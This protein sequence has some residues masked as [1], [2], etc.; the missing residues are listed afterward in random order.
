MFCPHSKINSSLF[1]SS[2]KS[3]STPAESNRKKFKCRSLILPILAAVYA[4]TAMAPAVRAEENDEQRVFLPAW[5]THREKHL[6]SLQLFKNATFRDN[7]PQLYGIT[8]PP[9]QPVKFYAE[10]EEVDAIYYVWIPDWYDS[11]F[12]DITQNIASYE[13]GV[14]IN[15]MVD[16]SSHESSIR[17][18]ISS[19]GGDPDHP[20]YVD[21]SPWPHYGDYALDSI[22]TVDSGPFWILDGAGNLGSVDMRYYFNRVNDDAIPAKIADLIGVTDYRPDLNFEGGNLASDGEGLC[23]GTFEHALV[24][25]PKTRYEVENDMELYLGCEK[26]IWLQKLVG[27][28]T[29]HV[30]MF[31]KMLGP[32]TIIV[33][34]Y[35]YAEDDVNSEILDQNAA[36][37]E[38]ETNANGDPLEVHRIP[39]PSHNNRQVWRTYTNS[40]AVNDLM[41]VPV[42]ANETTHEAQAL[43]VYETLLPG[44]TVI[45][46]NADSII[47]SGGA[48]HCV[49]RTRPIGVHTM[50]D[51]DPPYACEGDWEC[52]S[53]CGEFDY[54]G[55]CLFNHSVY[56]ENDENVVVDDC[57]YQ[58]SMCGWDIDEDYINCVSQGCGE[59]TEEGVCKTVDGSTYAV[60][61]E[62]N[63][64]LA[65]KCPPETNCVLDETLG[66]M[67]CLACEDECSMGDVGCSEDGR[68]E[69]VCGETG[70]GDPCIEPVLTECGD[71]EACQDGSCV[72]ICAHECD[73]GETGCSDNLQ[74]TWTCGLLND[75]DLC[76]DRIYDFCDV[77][78]YC[79][80]GVCVEGCMDECQEGDKGC[81]DDKTSRWECGEAG[82]GDDCLEPEFHACGSNKHCVE[83]ECVEGCADACSLGDTGCSEDNQS[84]WSCSETANED[85]CLYRVYED[86][87]P[88][89][90][91]KN[92]M[93]VEGCVD[94]C[95]MGESGC[96]SE[97]TSW[98]CGESVDGDDCLDRVETACGE[99][100]V[101]TQGTCAPPPPSGGSRSGCGCRTAPTPGETKGGLLLFLLVGVSLLTSKRKRLKTLKP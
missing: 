26:M 50:I 67:A 57:S 11:F 15:L 24:N 53:G 59:V 97:T 47:D 54:T 90:H 46:I 1:I 78:E 28:G 40:V 91:C 37:L 96:S 100:E 30:D 17:D 85:G 29:G 25:L 83:G 33:G 9:T 32:T 63:Y 49:T 95:R 52:T 79:E 7:N 70:D 86:C 73:D 65:A 88:N 36:L 5:E 43:S 12:W 10:H 44:K 6:P 77:G 71:T 16:S 94:A 75:G 8:T 55:D 19:Y 64:P 66:H 62:D 98:V 101:C 39:M 74:A 68:S 80:E 42:Y 4:L 82:D 72:T 14:E 76:R 34:E 60:W 48:I 87:G 21:M 45:G 18:L 41:L 56:C 84:R 58:D 23:F 81:T 3:T 22:W 92:S 99:G 38:S 51:D 13:P 69:W 20:N 31:S 89:S 61:C 27:E 93:C 2:S 35:D